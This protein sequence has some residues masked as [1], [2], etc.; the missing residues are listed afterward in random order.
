MVHPRKHGPCTFKTTFDFQNFN[1]TWYCRVIAPEAE[2]QDWEEEDEEGYP[3]FDAAKARGIPRPSDAI[4]IN[5]PKG[6]FGNGPQPLKTKA[7]IF[8]LN[9]ASLVTYSRIYEIV[10]VLSKDTRRAMAKIE[11][12]LGAVPAP[13]AE[14]KCISQELCFPKFG[15][16]FVNPTSRLA[17]KGTCTA[18]CIGNEVYHWDIYRNDYPIKLNTVNN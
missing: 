18:E 7:G 8:G 16:V 12:D 17:L 10:L 9:T 14:V 1:Y 15:G 4:L 6:C 11:L 2:Y 3:V 13:I 5:P